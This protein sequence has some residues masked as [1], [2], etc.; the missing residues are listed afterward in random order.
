MAKNNDIK[1]S[2]TISIVIC[3]LSCVLIATFFNVLNNLVNYSSLKK[4]E[5]TL[6]KG[7]ENEKIASRDL[8]KDK[9]YLESDEYIEEIARE[10]LGLIKSNEIL[11]V[12]SGD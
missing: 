6:I 2:L 1:K 12:P 11:F 3:G 9:E 8:A 5:Q 4:D 7:L 10:Q